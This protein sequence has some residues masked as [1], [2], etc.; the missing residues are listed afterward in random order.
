[1]SANHPY[2]QPKGAV[3]RDWPN[4]CERHPWLPPNGCE[5]S[6]STAANLDV[7]DLHEGQTTTPRTPVPYS[8]WIVC[9]FFNVPQLF[10]TKV[11]RRD[12]LLIVLIRIALTLCKHACK[13]D[14]EV[15]SWTDPGTPLLTW[16]W[17]KDAWFFAS[18]ET[19]KIAWFVKRR[20]KMVVM[21][22]EQVQRFILMK[23]IFMG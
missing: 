3:Q 8:L 10:A 2:L 15:K 21:C 20:K 13:V 23:K 12:P 17:T 11:V 5:W 6:R 18:F 7:F 14:C 1:M 16:L 22:F 4:A 19:Y 9:G